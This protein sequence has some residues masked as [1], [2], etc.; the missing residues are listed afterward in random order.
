MKENDAMVIATPGHWHALQTIQAC[1]AGNDVYVLEKPLSLCVAEGRAMV[2]AVHGDSR[3]CQVGIEAIGHY[4]G[5]TL[6][7]RRVLETHARPVKVPSRNRWSAPSN[8]KAYLLRVKFL[9][10]GFHLCLGTRRRS[11]AAA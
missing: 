11:Y 7:R 9:G 4:P 1:E 5:G 3:V 10:P 6:G 8:A 2:E